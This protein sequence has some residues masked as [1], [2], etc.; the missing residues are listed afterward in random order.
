MI[1][2][3]KK[4][5]IIWILYCSRY[6][7]IGDIYDYINII[8]GSFKKKIKLRQIDN[9]FYSKNNEDYENRIS[10]NDNNSKQLILDTN[11]F[12]MFMHKKSENTFSI[13]SKNRKEDH[14]AFFSHICQKMTNNEITT[15]ECKLVYENFLKKRQRDTQESKNLKKKYQEHNLLSITTTKNKI[16]ENLEF[17]NHIKQEVTNSNEFQKNKNDIENLQQQNLII[18]SNEKIQNNKEESELSSKNVNLI[19]KNKRKKRLKIS[20]NNNNQIH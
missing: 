9:N 3:D 4:T 2:F 13:T 1:G 12:C 15:N 14:H 10:I 11:Y 17:N 8:F 20:N 7:T 16:N 6:C 18:H 5:I 19:V